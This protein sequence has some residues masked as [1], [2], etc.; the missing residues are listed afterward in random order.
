MLF[1]DFCMNPADNIINLLPDGSYIG[2]ITAYYTKCVGEN[3]IN[4][5]LADVLKKFTDVNETFNNITSQSSTFNQSYPDCLPDLNDITSNIKIIIENLDLLGEQIECGPLYSAWNNI[6]NIGLCS[7][8]FSG[9]FI[10]WICQFVTSGMLFIVMCIASVM[11]L[12]YHPPIAAMEGEAV[13]YKEAEYLDDAPGAIEEGNK[14]FYEEPA[15]E[16]YHHDHD[17]E[18]VTKQN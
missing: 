5:T 14:D 2:N 9:L 12:Q 8:G 3:P 18:M 10:L 1:G 15:G 4:D 17:V 16:Q 11:F 7:N 6:V 13:A